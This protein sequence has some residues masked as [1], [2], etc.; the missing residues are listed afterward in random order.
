MHKIWGIMDFLDAIL[1]HPSNAGENYSK[2]NP[3][4]FGKI[5][6]KAAAMLSFFS[7]VSGLC[8][9]FR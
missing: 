3:Q 6:N 7:I 5:H 1:F 9:Q 4:Q 2:T 8:L